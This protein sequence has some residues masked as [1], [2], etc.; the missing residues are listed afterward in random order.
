[1][2][3]QPRLQAGLLTWAAFAVAALLPW[4]LFAV[5]IYS[6]RT[7]ITGGESLTNAGALW[8]ILSPMWFAGACWIAHREGRQVL[9]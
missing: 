4:L 9:R 5:A 1:M 6:Q 2:M 7:G 8:L 3:R